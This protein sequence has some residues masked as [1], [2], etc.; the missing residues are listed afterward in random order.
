[1]I[2]W[3]SNFLADHVWHITYRCHQ[4][5]FLLKFARDRERYLHWLA[6]IA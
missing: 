5:E 3:D 6:L 2:Q 1:M 4:K